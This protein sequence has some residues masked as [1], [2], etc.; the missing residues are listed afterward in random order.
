M[1]I[2]KPDA[3]PAEGPTASGAVS[4]GLTANLLKAVAMGTMLLD[5]CAI[6]FLPAG[7]TPWIF[8]RVLGRL[9]MP[10]FCRM[11]AE[12]CFH[13]SSLRRYALRLLAAAAAAHVPYALFFD[14]DP[15][16]ETSVLWALLMG[17]L[18]LSLWR[19]AQMPVPIRLAGIAALCVLSLPADWSYIAVLWVLCFGC[20]RDRPKLQMWA[21]A[22]VGMIF[23][24]LPVADDVL[25][26]PCTFSQY[27]Y[28][29]G[30]LLAVPLL[31]AYHGV[32]GTR[33]TALRWGFYLFYPVHLA[34][35]CL[36]K[37]VCR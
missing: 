22:A 32:L 15:L 17:L 18:A 7:S 9:S 28:Q 26:V 14:R 6:G 29:L 20:F 23:Y 11:V 24:V 13:T 34:V 31:T 37:G 21:F 5:H 35:L 16:R 19:R 4:A 36:W 27:G 1:F 2:R 8:M 3:L 25:A 33:S 10:V 12:G 30:Y